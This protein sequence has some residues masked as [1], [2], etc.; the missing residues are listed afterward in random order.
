[1]MLSYNLEGENDNDSKW[2]PTTLY[3]REVTNV[4]WT[5]LPNSKTNA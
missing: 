3:Y 2:C 5:L 4:P 1:M